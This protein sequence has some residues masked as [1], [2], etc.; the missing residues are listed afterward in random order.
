MASIFLERLRSGE[1]LV[2]DGATGTNYQRMG[3]ELGVFP[4]EWVLDDPD[5]VRGLHRAYI[6]AGADIILTDTFGGTRIRLRDSKYTGRAAEINRRAAE[7]AREAASGTGVLVAGSMGPS[8]QLCE[9]LGELTEADAIAA[10][11][12]QAQALADGG[13]DFLLLETFFALDEA[14]AAIHGCKQVSTLPLVVTFS[15]DQGT[16]TMMGLSPTKVVQAIT[17]LGVDVIGAN[18]GKTLDSMAQI[19]REIASL[20]TGLPIWAKPNAGLP[21]MEG[22]V[23]VYD[24]TPETMADYSLRFIRD[25]AQ[26]VGGCCGN[27]PEH[28]AAIAS[29][30]KHS[31]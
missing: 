2:A 13:V 12:E 7:L 28:I 25:G 10:F 17:P 21:R 1:H 31:S 26:V 3:L 4:E 18:C 19:V 23:A 14:T 11:A 24:T 29:A 16:R 6:A 5:K 22:D 27:T 8:G 30:V 20:K 9:P 15:Y